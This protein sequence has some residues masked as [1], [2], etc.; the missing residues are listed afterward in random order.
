MTDN[1][2]FSKGMRMPTW[3]PQTTLAFMASNGIETSILSCALPLTVL[4]QGNTTKAATLTREVSDYLAS[5]RTQHPTQFGFFAS[6]PSLED[7][8]ICIDEIRHAVDDLHAEGVLL[9]TS[10]N[11]KYLGHPD[12]ERVW[13]ELNARGTVV[14]THPTIDGATEK[15]I[16]EPFTIPPPLLDWTHETTRAAVHLILTNTLRRFPECKIILSHGGGTLPFIVGRMADLQTRLS[17]RSEE[18]FLEDARRLYFDIALVGPPV[19]P[20]QL[21]R[22]F[23]GSGHVLFG[24]DFP[25]V[26]AEG[27]ARRWDGVTAGGGEELVI[28]TRNAT[29]VLFPRLMRG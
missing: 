25:F 12:F 26:A 21:V 8:E 23:A 22:E 18:D 11:G 4:A 17:G 1:P 9:F 14:F 19:T 13:D 16:Q 24:T 5:L 27:V 6:I 3:S 20:L 15:C 7:T 2:D 29:Q 10:Y 28:E